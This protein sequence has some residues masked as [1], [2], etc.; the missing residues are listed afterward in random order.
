MPISLPGVV[1]ESASADRR[2]ITYSL[3]GSAST[4]GELVARLASVA[5]LRDIS[6]QEPA[7]EDVIARL[8]AAGR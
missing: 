3:D 2:L 1:E 6:V 7:I 8:Y 4:A 5:S